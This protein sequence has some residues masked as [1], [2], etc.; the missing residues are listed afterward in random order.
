M[1]GG[2]VLTVLYHD[3]FDGAASA[4]MLMALLVHMLC[5]REFDFKAIDYGNDLGWT[6]PVPGVLGADFKGDFA[7]VDFQYHPAAKYFFDHHPTA[8]L[9]PEWR[10]QCAE[11]SVTEYCQ[12]APT[13]SCAELIWTAMPPEAQLYFERLR[14]A[15]NLID[16]ARYPTPDDYFQATSPEIGISVAWHRLSPAEKV[17]VIARLAK[18]DIEGARDSIEAHVSA[19][20]A[21]N[22]AQLDA[23]GEYCEL[24][25]NT[26]IVDC[27]KARSG[28]VRFAPFYYHPTAKYALTLFSHEQDVRTSLGKNPWLAFDPLNEGIDLGAIAKRVG[29]GGHPF[30]AGAAFRQSEHPFPYIEAW[31]FVAGLARELTLASQPAAA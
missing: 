31:R 28:M 18:V 7:V 27:V 14:T 21:E 19:A 12:W 10:K 25:G 20:V 4:A 2:G 22:L 24:R 17:G 9:Q 16:G 13:V 3:D 23:V 8:F 5:E 26:V 29:G 11:R 6:K 15:A 1:G 30:A